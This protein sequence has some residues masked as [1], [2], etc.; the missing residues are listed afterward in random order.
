MTKIASIN[1]DAAKFLPAS[2]YEQPADIVAEPLLTRG[3]KIA[4]LQRWRQQIAE[5]L[6][7]GD[8][9]MPTR[10]TSGRNHDLIGEIQTALDELEKSAP[11]N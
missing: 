11:S 9:G 4:T 8:E 3:E 1:R 5:E 2:Q 6:T 7:A 10:H